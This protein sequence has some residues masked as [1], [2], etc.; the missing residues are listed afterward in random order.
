M[1]REAWQDTIYRITKSQ[2]WLKWLSTHTDI[3]VFHMASTVLGFEK[4]RAESDTTTD[5]A[6]FTSSVQFSHSVMSLQSHGLQ[7]A[8]PPCLSPTLKIYL[9]SCPLSQWCHPT[10]SSSVI[11]FSSCLHSF[12]ESGSFPLSQFF[13]SSG[14]SIGASASASVLPMNIQDWF[15][16]GWTCWITLKSK[17]LSRVFSKT[18]VQK[19]QFIG[20]QLSLYSNSHI[21]TWLLEKP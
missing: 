7:H 13:E 6:V 19:H 21:H 17:G 16:L 4:N 8:R 2:K 11:P 1:D 14:Q 18:T 12:P 9:N 20:T 15:T 5:L 10:I 3:E